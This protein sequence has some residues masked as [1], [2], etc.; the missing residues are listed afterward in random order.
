MRCVTCGEPGASAHSCPSCGAG[1]KPASPAALEAAFSEP[2]PPLGG[3]RVGHDFGPR[4]YIA[5]TLG[6]GGM[7]IVYKALDREL[8]VSVALKMLRAP[9]S[10]KMA[11]ELQRRFTSEL[12]LARQ[13]TH[14][15]VI[16]IH[17]IGEVNGI[18]F[19]SMPFID[20]DDLGTPLAEG[21]LPLARTLRYA[22]HLASG[23]MAVH[24]AGVVHRDIKPANVMIGEG[25]QAV[26]MDF[27][28]AKSSA[29][30]ATQ[31]TAPGASPGTLAYMAPEQARGEQADQR[32]DIYA[33]GLLL[34]EMI[35]GTRELSVVEILGRLKSA[36]PSLRASHPEVPEALDA[37]VTR[38]LQPNPSKRFQTAVELA[39]AIAGLP[40]DRRG[41][42]PVA[43]YAKRWLPRAAAL[44][45][46]AA[47]LALGHWAV[48]NGV[49]TKLARSLMPESVAAEDADA[50]LV[51][52]P[53]RRSSSEGGS[54]SGNVEEAIAPRPV[55]ATGTAF[56][57]PS[58][59]TP[60]PD[61]RDM[62][63]VGR[64]ADEKDRVGRVPRSGPGG[65]NAATAALHRGDFK[66]AT[67]EAEQAITA[68]PQSPAAYLSLAAAAAMT[69]PD[70]A[71]AA[72]ERM[73]ATGS[74]GASQ[75]A[76]GLADLALYERRYSVAAEIL[77]S[78]I[79]RDVLT[80]DRAGL[81][82]KYIELAEARVGQG[83]R[84]AAVTAVGQALGTS[85]DESVLLPAA[86]LYITLDRDDD[87]RA[88]AKELGA[89]TD[90]NSRAYGRIVDADLALDR[91]DTAG[92]IETL[93]LLLKTTDFWLVR[94]V[95]G[96][97]YLQSKQYPEAMEQLNWCEVRQGEAATLFRDDEPSIRYLGMLRDLL[98]RAR[99]GAGLM[100]EAAQD[101][102]QSRVLHAG[103]P[104]GTAERDARMRLTR[105]A[106]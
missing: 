47:L 15:N 101:V 2:P 91:G 41:G 52:R 75:A 103:S 45:L 66:T 89:A 39:Q 73:K 40:R 14:K 36:P 60:A 88:L 65:A 53:V 50:G 72:Y 81:A 44:A 9:G 62:D 90:D 46:V 87:A 69:S 54:R 94:L 99:A 105:A 28:I 3:P 29:P 63:D 84:G 27:G 97:A 38:C 35:T 19:I 22:R 95:L 6:A 25:D 18:R 106:D 1:R 78:A 20:G 100:R 76:A 67:R 59:T 16:R 55:G 26:L 58:T 32:T 96:N 82:T 34:Q 70:S 64:V 4:Y 57:G 42:V 13:I 12:L 11:A 31:Y 71:R 23:L 33:F 98:A 37:I 77:E 30:G 102:R 8:N 61:I 92:A 7:G 104:N 5:K 10:L 48:T 17:D 68:N 21:R 49:V 80:P 83:R 74:A 79:A 43:A 85:R 86:R 56:E 51:P 93:R 24:A